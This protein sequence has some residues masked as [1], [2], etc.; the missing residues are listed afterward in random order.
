MRR[1]RRRGRDGWLWEPVIPQ[2]HEEPG[3]SPAPCFKRCWTQR[4]SSSSAPGRELCH[5]IVPVPIRRCQQ[6]GSVVVTGV[7]TT[8]SFNVAGDGVAVWD[9]RR[10]AVAPRELVSVR[11]PKSHSRSRHVPRRPFSVTTGS[12]LAVESGLEHDL[13]RILDPDPSVA[14][15]VPQ[16]CVLEFVGEVGRLR[17]VPDLL[18]LSDQG[19][20]TIWDVRPLARAD[21]R[22]WRTAGLTREACAEV[23]WGFEVFHGEPVPQRLN[24]LW[25]NGFRHSRPW[26]AAMTWRIRDAITGSAAPVTIGDLL[27]MDPGEGELTST[28]WHLI[29]SHQLSCDLAGSLADSTVV[30]LPAGQV[31]A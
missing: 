4:S 18:A 9:W 11:E 13:I 27:Q 2:T 16:P 20:V 5:A 25:L 22:F 26:H 21:E 17:H 29:W 8:W 6:L 15:L 12:S 30:T 28:L 19:G 24:R 7:A 10:G 3:G 14:W 1:R 31:R 23:G